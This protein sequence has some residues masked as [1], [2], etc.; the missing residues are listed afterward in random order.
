MKNKNTFKRI[1]IF[2]AVL[3]F[4]LFILVVFLPI[5][6]KTI[7]QFPKLDQLTVG[8]QYNEYR[9]DTLVNRT[10]SQM[11]REDK[12]GQLFMVSITGTGVTADTK[13]LIEEYHIGSIVLM[14]G[15]IA[16]EGQVKNL[17]ADLNNLSPTKLL[18]ATD[19]EGGVVA[20]IPWD[21]ARFISQPHIGTVNREDF[22]YETGKQHAEALAQL[23]INANLAPVL[24]ISFIGGSVMAS[25]A[26]G[27]SPDK[28]ANLGK[29]IIT[30]H[31]DAGIITT[32]KH[33]PGI[34]RSTTDS[35]AL[36]P[37]INISRE[38]LLTE[39]LVPFKTAIDEG[40]DMIMIGHALYPQIDPDYP[41]SLSKVLVTDILRSDLGYTGVIITDDLRMGALNNYP[42]KF[43]D[44]FNAGNDILLIV[45]SSSN[46]MQYIV[47]LQNSD[48]DESRLE[49]SVKRILR[50]K[51]QYGI[52]DKTTS[53]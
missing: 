11:S 49:Q 6:T 48:I 31:H 51:A 19:Q 1:I 3:S 14:S 10:Y 32:A 13:K 46:Q 4:G 27:A 15:N 18:F 45:D 26:L 50:L 52:L 37:T 22:A 16:T 41:A 35:H 17:I 20:R 39:E 36:T 44:A 38:T 23:D 8:E 28:V 2:S 33:Y 24:D 21:D 43:K 5:S 40:V 47:S 34:G 30:A 53:G 29:Q 25:R 9:I 42:D 7:S 12:I